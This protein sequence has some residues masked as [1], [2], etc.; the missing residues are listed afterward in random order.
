MS[1]KKTNK[2]KVA[3]RKVPDRD[4]FYMGMA[5]WMAS[6][7]KDPNT[8]N[9]AI[10]VAESNIIIGTGYNGPPASYKDD[11]LDWT[12]D[13]K[14]INKYDHIIHAEENA[15]IH[16]PFT[17]L[18]PGSTIYV[19]AR[20]CKGCMLRIAHAQLRKVVFF[21]M[22]KDAGS[23]LNKDQDVVEDIIRRSK[24]TVEEFKGNLNWMR[25]RMSVM[26]ELGI[27]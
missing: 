10:I 20:P 15:I 9:A 21:P 12:R 26:E 17:L 13:P 19:T 4:D 6:K 18:I 3:P 16:C 14:K 7:S 8:Q 2:D 5:F 23:M 1:N 24:L 25:D 27:F 11:E 22:Q